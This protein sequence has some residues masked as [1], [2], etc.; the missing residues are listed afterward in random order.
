MNL[1]LMRILIDCQ[2]SEPPLQLKVNDVLA[3]HIWLRAPGGAGHG[4]VVI[5][6]PLVGVFA[7]DS[8]FDLLLKEEDSEWRP[9]GLD[10]LRRVLTAQKCLAK[11]ESQTSA[12]Q[13]AEL[14]AQGMSN[15]VE[16]LLRVGEVTGLDACI[17]R[18]DAALY[19]ASI[20]HCRSALVFVVPSVLQARK[21]L[22]GSG[23][24]PHPQYEAVLVDP[25]SGLTIRL[26]ER[27]PGAR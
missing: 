25:Q 21:G 17:Q 20:P 19:R 14:G 2:R 24:Y 6:D 11:S 23:L 26:L 5:E 12:R 18:I 16:K 1:L 27:A 9:I 7:L 4:E 10:E 13:T 15:A 8:E 3:K 22:R